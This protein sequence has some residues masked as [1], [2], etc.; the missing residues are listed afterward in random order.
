M[1]CTYEVIAIV[2]TWL[3]AI[4]TQLLK[5]L[6]ATSYQPTQLLLFWLKAEC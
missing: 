5:Q 1:A 6:S 2:I 3:S 4:S